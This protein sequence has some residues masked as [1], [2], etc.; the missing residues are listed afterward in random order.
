MLSAISMTTTSM[1]T[2]VVVFM[3]FSMVLVHRN[4]NTTA[5][6]DQQDPDYH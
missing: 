4:K 1:A 5:E 6:C 2:T 3:S